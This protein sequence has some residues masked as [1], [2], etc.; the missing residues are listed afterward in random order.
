[1]KLYL[2]SQNTANGYDVYD[3]AVVCCDTEDEARN[4]NPSNGKSMEWDKSIWDWCLKASDVQ[5]RYLGEAAP[6]VDRGVVC[7]SFNAG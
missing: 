6:T 7:A 2:I 5:V 4:M 1:M 3:S